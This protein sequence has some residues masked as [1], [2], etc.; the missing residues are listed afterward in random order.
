MIARADRSGRP[1]RGEQ[2]EQIA[3]AREKFSYSLF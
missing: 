2:R 1:P 3:R